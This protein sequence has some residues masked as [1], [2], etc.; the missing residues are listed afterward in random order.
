MSYG[1]PYRTLEGRTE[2]K[3]SRR[4]REREGFYTNRRDTHHQRLCADQVGP[5]GGVPYHH[6]PGPS[7]TEPIQAYQTCRCARPQTARPTCWELLL[8]TWSAVRCLL[9]LAIR[10]TVLLVVRCTRVLAIG[11]V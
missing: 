9:V 5:Q 4:E 8:F 2:G 10:C 3:L 6:L 1:R 11:D 7:Q